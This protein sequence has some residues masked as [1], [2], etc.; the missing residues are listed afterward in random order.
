MMSFYVRHWVL[1]ERENC[2]DLKV[3]SE[4]SLSRWCLKISRILLVSESNCA[5]LA[6]LIKL[7]FVYKKVYSKGFSEFFNDI[8]VYLKNGS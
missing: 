3:T 1:S 2:A 4:T 5:E 6:E 7:V 8:Y